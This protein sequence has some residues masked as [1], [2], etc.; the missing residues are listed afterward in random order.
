MVF[1]EIKLGW[2]GEIYTCPPNKVWK[3]IRHLETKGV[4]IMAITSTGSITSKCSALSECLNFLGME[5]F[6]SDEEV[7]EA[8]FSD[9]NVNL[10]EV[11][12][13]LQMMVV[14]PSVRKRA[15]EI[16]EEEAAKEMEGLE[17]KPVKAKEKV[18]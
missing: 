5:N 17:K 14:P 4:D 10:Q 11:M 2:G 16:T 12:L 6:P 8:L 3:M 13:A 9:D 18:S 1:E 15:L 7:Y